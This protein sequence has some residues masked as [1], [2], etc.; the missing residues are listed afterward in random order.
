MSADLFTTLVVARLRSGGLEVAGQKRLEVTLRTGDSH[1]VAQLD[2]Y[3]QRYRR[4]PGDL[5]PLIQELIDAVREGDFKKTIVGSF[6]QAAPDLLPM[7]VTGK[8]WQKRMDEGIHLAVRPLVQELGIAIVIDEPE[9]ITFVQTEMLGAWHIDYDTAFD[10]AI[11]NLEQRAKSIPYSQNGE[12]VET[13]LVDKA[14]DGYAATRGILPSRLQDWAKRVP[15]D[16]VIGVPRRDFLV[17]C[18]STHP[19]IDAIAEQV[20]KDQK[21]DEHGLASG[22]LVYKDNRLEQF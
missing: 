7:L 5:T 22:L 10:A 14:G 19:H 4:E 11:G 16:L 20:E 2:S 15:G 21:A 18:G 1:I 13:I 8:D 6:E 3:Y 17:G 9:L 12:G